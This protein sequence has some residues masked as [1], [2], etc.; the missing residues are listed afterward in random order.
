MPGVEF[1]EHRQVGDDWPN[2]RWAHTVTPIGRR[3]G[4]LLFG[5]FASKVYRNDAWLLTAWGTGGGAVR[6][7]PS[8]VLVNPNEVA[9]GYRGPDAS[10]MV[11]RR[12]P[13]AMSW[14]P[15]VR[16][17]HTA[18]AMDGAVIIYGG[19]EG[20]KKL[21]DA[22]VLMTTQGDTEIAS[23]GL[24]V[25][26][27]S[28]TFDTTSN[29]AVSYA[30]PALAFAAGAQLSKT[31][32]II[33]SGVGKSNSGEYA[34]ALVCTLMQPL[35]ALVPAVTPSSYKTV[36]RLPDSRMEMIEIALSGQEVPAA[37]KCHAM[38]AAPAP[39]LPPL[40]YHICTP[41]QSHVGP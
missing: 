12:D 32:F 22:F 19:G 5:G 38:C 9:A 15:S 7:R 21:D 34:G 3:E 10:H 35:S 6:L 24:C 31:S 41:E 20:K 23:G 27:Q 13:N 16:S 4:A 17:N 28:N 11:A 14:Y 39:I 29:T 30:L 2:A 40:L 18:F 25:A 36:H 26:T 1:K 37:R 8:D 33:F